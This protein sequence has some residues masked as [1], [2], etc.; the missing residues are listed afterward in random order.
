MNNH[1]T[2]SNIL[3]Q[4]RYRRHPNI[5]IFY[6]TFN[7]FT[8]SSHEDNADGA[9]AYFT[10][11]SRNFQSNA[12]ERETKCF[13]VLISHAGIMRSKIFLD[14]K[15][16]LIRRR[17][18]KIGSGFNNLSIFFRWELRKAISFLRSLQ[19]YT[20]IE[21]VECG[22]KSTK[23]TSLPATR[24]VSL[25]RPEFPVGGFASRAPALAALL[26]PRQRNCVPPRSSFKLKRKRFMSSYKI[27]QIFSFL[28]T[29]CSPDFP[30]R[31]RASHSRLES[32]TEASL[33]AANVTSIS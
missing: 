1:A 16:L 32:G 14:A 28:S 29:F 33:T 17:Y 25:S 23:F 2:A 6:R 13:M 27:T 30:A 20:E 8:E 19:H 11:H 7:K 31:R 15:S 9:F 5:D 3:R 26:P 21:T 12:L 10:H 24:G 22:K 4:I 18:A